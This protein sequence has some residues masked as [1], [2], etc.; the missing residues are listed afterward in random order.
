MQRDDFLAATLINVNFAGTLL[1]TGRSYVSNGENRL[2]GTI[3]AVAAIQCDGAVPVGIP[4][5]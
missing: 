3:P 4:G 2:E 1:P 5:A